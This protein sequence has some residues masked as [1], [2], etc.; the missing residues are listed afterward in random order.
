MMQDNTCYGIPHYVAII[1]CDITEMQGFLLI[2]RRK[3]ATHLAWDQTN[4]MVHCQQGQILLHLETTFWSV[5][6]Q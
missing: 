3:K 6:L 4:S 5:K 2:T 1:C